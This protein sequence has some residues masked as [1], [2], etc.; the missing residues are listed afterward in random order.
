M[1]HLKPFEEYITENNIMYFSDEINNAM[2]QLN[3]IAQVKPSNDIIHPVISRIDD[4]NVKQ[5]LISNTEGKTDNNLPLI[6]NI[7][8]SLSGSEPHTFFWNIQKLYD[9]TKKEARS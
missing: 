9:K 8:R 4:D 1:K 3:Y 5:L 2:K 6:K 7:L